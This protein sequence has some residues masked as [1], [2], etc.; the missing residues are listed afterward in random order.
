MAP[1]TKAQPAA[2]SAA[3]HRHTLAIDVGGTGLKASVLDEEGKMMTDRV[4]VETPVGAPPAKI[5]AAL[6]ALVKPLPAFD[7]VSVGFPGVVRDG[8]VF[9]APNL[10][11]DG[12]RGF[13][14]AGALHRRLGKPVR[15]INDADMQGLGVIRGRGIEMVV[16]LG[17]GFGTGLYSH[18][19][20][21]PHLEI[22]HHPFRKGEDYDQQLG[23]AAREK[24]GNKKWNRRVRI[25]ID[26]LRRLVNFDRL[27]VGGGNAKHVSFK[28][29]PDVVLVDNKAG[30]EGGIA[31]WREFGARNSDARRR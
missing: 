25:A 27:Y 6:A 7:R 29:G 23:E 19:R 18:G 28:P 17:T 15:V 20:L 3:S 30:I 31:L 10:R 13:D 24:I 14:L 16:T 5:V 4:R 8:V 9:T 11:N 22:A 12:W 26:T 21:A 2:G 1:R